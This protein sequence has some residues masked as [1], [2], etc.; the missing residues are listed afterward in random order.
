MNGAMTSFRKIIPILAAVIAAFALT[1][2]S[3]AW[4]W[5]QA[6]TYSLAAITA[7]TIAAVG[8]PYALVGPGWLW[9]LRNLRRGELKEISIVNVHGLDAPTFLEIDTFTFY[10]ASSRP[11]RSLQLETRTGGAEPDPDESGA[12]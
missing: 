10:V 2:L 11:S 4:N 8:L 3:E 6:L 9:A 12:R 1:A 5:S 7:V